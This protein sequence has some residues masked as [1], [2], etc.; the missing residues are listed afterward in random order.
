MADLG[1]ANKMAII[2][3]SSFMITLFLSA[4]LKKKTN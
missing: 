4:L 2:M 1:D 3:G